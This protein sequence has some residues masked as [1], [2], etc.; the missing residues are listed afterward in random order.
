MVFAGERGLHERKGRIFQPVAS[1]L[2]GPIAI[3]AGAGIYGL[4]IGA[5]SIWP[6]SLTAWRRA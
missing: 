6:I 2:F 5:I 1:V 3:A 4:A